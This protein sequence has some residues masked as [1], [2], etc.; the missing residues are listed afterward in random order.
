MRVVGKRGGAG[1]WDEFG[2]SQPAPAQLSRSDVAVSRQRRESAAPA[3][4]APLIISAFECLIT[5][6]PSPSATPVTG[7]T[8]ARRRGWCEAGCSGRLE[9]L[10]PKSDGFHPKSPRC[11]RVGPPSPPPG[12]L[13]FRS[14]TRKGG[15]RVSGFA[16]LTVPGTESEPVK[17]QPRG[18]RGF[19]TRMCFTCTCC[20]GVHAHACGYTHTRVGPPSPPPPPKRAL[21]SA[22]SRHPHACAQL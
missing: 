11:R 4:K 13:R 9:L 21:P 17:S 19:W 7:P 2:R 14:D 16:A 5:A 3:A 15:N 1:E 20:T 12:F 8:L 10:S 18:T 6:Q 22:A